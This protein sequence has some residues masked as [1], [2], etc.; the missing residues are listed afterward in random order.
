MKTILL[1]GFSY[2]VLVFL[3]GFVLGVIRVLLL[4]PEIGE[5]YAELVEMPLMLIAIYFSARLIVNRFVTLPRLSDYLAVG[6]LAL[7]LLLLIEFTLVLKL[8]EISVAEYISSRDPVSSTA[9]A[10]SLLIYMLMPVLVA[11]K[12]RRTP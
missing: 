5:Q 2:F 1:Y 3:A 11:K 10:V 12:F 8:R 4:V 6:I 9:Y 7:T